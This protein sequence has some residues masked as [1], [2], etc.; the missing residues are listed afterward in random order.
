VNKLKLVGLRKKKETESKPS[1][2]QPPERPKSKNFK[3]WSSKE[4]EWS[5]FL[6]EPI[7]EEN[8]ACLILRNNQ[9]I[10]AIPENNSI[11]EIR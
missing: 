6:A 3:I 1:L 10:W 2:N 4:K 9:L 11:P 8:G 5:F 7:K